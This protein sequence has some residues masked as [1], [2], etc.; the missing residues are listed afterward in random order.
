MSQGV[1]T[2]YLV[3]LVTEQVDDHALVVWYDPRGALPGGCVEPSSPEITVARYE[4]SFFQLRHEIEP[5]MNDLHPPRL[6]V[7]VPMGREKDP[8]T[9][10]PADAKARLSRSTSKGPQS[11]DPGGC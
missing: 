1:V 8:P 10:S 3:N 7:Y 9:P 2:A 6:V 11:R 5:L 4:G